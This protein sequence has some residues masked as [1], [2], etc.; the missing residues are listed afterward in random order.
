M[1]DRVVSLFKNGCELK[2]ISILIENHYER[3]NV[4][5]DPKRISQVLVNLMNNAVK[6]TNY[7][8]KIIIKVLPNSGYIQIQVI[9]D[10]IGIENNR[11]QMI[12]KVLYERG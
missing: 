4:R 6:F 2:K 8:G 5:S 7:E 11:L 3:M 12:R 9:D 10:G 1:L